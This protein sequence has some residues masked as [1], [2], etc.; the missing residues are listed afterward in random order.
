MHALQQVRATHAVAAAQR[1]RSMQV[2]QHAWTYRPMVHDVL[3]MSLNRI[4]LEADPPQAR[5]GPYPELCTAGS[6]LC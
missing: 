6:Q 1:A 5:S 4:T 2:L 3:G